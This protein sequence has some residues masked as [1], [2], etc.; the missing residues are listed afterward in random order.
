MK[1]T[2]WLALKHLQGQKPVETLSKDGGMDKR[3]ICT[4][5]STRGHAQLSD[6]LAKAR[7]CAP[8]SHS[9]SALLNLVGTCS[10]P[11]EVLECLALVSMGACVS[12]PMG[13]KQSERQFLAGYHLQTESHSPS[14]CEKGLFT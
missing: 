4:L 7:G 12:G 9:P 1:E 2:D 11:R 13:P 3:H 10:L 5:P 8:N 6:Y 14:S